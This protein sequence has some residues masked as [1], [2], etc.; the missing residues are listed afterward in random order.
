[1]KAQIKKKISLLCVLICLFSASV[2][3]RLWTINQAGR[4]WDEAAYVERGHTFLELARKGDFINSYWYKNAD[5]PPF[6]R[7]VY[8]LASYGDIKGHDKYGKPVFHYNYTYSRLASITLSSLSV[9]LV[10]AMGWEFF[11][12]VIGS[13]AGVIL[14]LIP[15]FLGLSQLATLESFIMFFF[16]AAFY[17]FIRL[18]KKVTFIRIFVTGIAVGLALLSKY[19]N[20]WLLPIFVWTYAVWYFYTGR[21][22]RKRFVNKQVLLLFPVVALTIFLLWPM[23]WF[24]IKEV[25]AASYNWR[26]VGSK[27]SVPEVFFGK[28]VLVPNVYYVIMFLITTPLLLLLLFVCG[29]LFI[30]NK[31]KKYLAKNQVHITRKIIKGIPSLFLFSQNRHNRSFQR[32]W[33]YYGLVIWFVVP[34]IQSFYNFRQH[35]I[36]YIIEIYAPFSLIAALGFDYLAAFLVKRTFWK[37]ILFLPIIG[38]LFII[39]L[40]ISPYYLDYFNELVGGTKS[41]YEKNL[42]QIGWWG[43]G[44]SEAVY[45]VDSH[46]LCGDTIGAAV[47]PLTSIPPV[48]CK[49]IEQYN[50]NQKYTYVIVST[51]NIAREGFDDTLIKKEYKPVYFV[52][53]DGAKLVTVYERKK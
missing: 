19:T 38:Y 39:I 32:Q 20:I 28:L 2:G 51:F 52:M 26:I 46:S 18:M 15:F 25:L 17:S 31:N 6:A 47:V 48:S 36:R 22:E 53:A 9:V 34:F 40:R 12:P 8:G 4:T 30:S 50:K 42:F 35:G 37:S 27:Y 24:H 14:A 33:M 29:L 11:S 41:V 10:T 23:P 5:A 1:M 13:V 44:I 7:Y 16:T 21:H 49:R 3:I 43:Q 45:Y